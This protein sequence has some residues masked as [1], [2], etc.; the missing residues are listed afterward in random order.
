MDVKEWFSTVSAAMSPSNTFIQAIVK[1]ETPTVSHS[2]ILTEEDR[3]N[4]LLE[5]LIQIFFTWAVYQCFACMPD[6]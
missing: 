5:L 1:T 4:I 6:A 3:K 2:T